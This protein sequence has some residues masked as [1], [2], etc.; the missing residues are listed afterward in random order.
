SDKMEKFSDEFYKNNP[1]KILHPY[2]YNSIWIHTHPG[3]SASPSSTDL[4][5]FKDR[6]PET[7][8]IMY[9][10]AKGGEQTARMKVAG[11]GTEFKMTC[12]EIEADKVYTPTDEDKEEW[13][14]LYKDN[15]EE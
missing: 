4:D 5:T 2:Q 1:D 3:N 10:L 7:F 9:I 8:F 14:K 12:S 15:I 6:N 13:T 11:C